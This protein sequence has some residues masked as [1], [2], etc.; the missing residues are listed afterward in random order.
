MTL[1][2]DIDPGKTLQA[3]GSDDFIRLRV[4]FFFSYPKIKR[5]LDST[6]A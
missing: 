3:F 4:S 6:D 2:I 1:F 5:V